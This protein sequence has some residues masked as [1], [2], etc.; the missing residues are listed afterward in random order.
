MYVVG[1]LVIL[2]GIYQIHSSIKYLSNLK[3]NGGKDTSPF[4]LY[5]I[6]SSFLIGGFMMFF[7]FGTM[8]F[9]NW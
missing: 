9:F 4:I 8:F 7:G 6:Y 1:I 3:T 5:A 2:L